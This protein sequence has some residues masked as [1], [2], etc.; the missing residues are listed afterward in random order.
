MFTAG[1]RNI[2]LDLMSKLGPSTRPDLYMP[3]LK[4]LESKYGQQPEVQILPGDK[5][6]LVSG[7]GD[8]QIAHKDLWFTIRGFEE[9]LYKRGCADTNVQRKAVVFGYNIEVDWSIPVW[10]IEHGGGMG[11]RGGK[12]DPFLAVFMEETLNKEDWGF[13]NYPLEVNTL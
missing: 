4:G 3:L 2:Q 7:C 12:N 5:Y 9:R 6:S 10:H 8:F 1:K 11:G 13:S